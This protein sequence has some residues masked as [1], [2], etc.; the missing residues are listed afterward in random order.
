MAAADKVTNAGLASLA[1]N[2]GTFFLSLRLLRRLL[3]RYPIFALIFLGNTNFEPPALIPAFRH[4]RCGALIIDIL[5]DK[6][7]TMPCARRR[8]QCW[9]R[10]PARHAIIML[11]GGDFSPT[12]LMIDIAF[13][14]SRAPSAAVTPRRRAHAKCTEML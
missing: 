12:T 10:F 6:H 9:S 7:D 14:T 13:T 8:C 5:A 11:E 1:N 2:M 4:A 3:I